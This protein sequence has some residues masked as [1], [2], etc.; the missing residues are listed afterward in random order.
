MADLKILIP[1]NGIT[2]DDD[3]FITLTGDSG[4]TGIDISLVENTP[5]G[6][7]ESLTGFPL[8]NQSLPTS[9]K[10]GSNKSSINIPIEFPSVGE[11]ANSKKTYLLT[12]TGTGGT[13]MGP[14]T[15]THGEL[16]SNSPNNSATM[17]F[18]QYKD[19]TIRVTATITRPDPPGTTD[20]WHF[21]DPGWTSALLENT[22]VEQ[23]GKALTSVESLKWRS[24]ARGNVS[25]DFEMRVGRM[26][27][28]DEVV[29]KAGKEVLVGWDSNDDNKL[30]DFTQ[31]STDHGNV[32]EIHSLAITRVEQ[33]WSVGTIEQVLTGTIDFIKYGT[34]DVTFNIELTDIFECPTCG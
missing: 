13:M 14:Y 6:S 1:Q 31:N 21:T 5:G 26:L 25:V 27:T 11:E 20:T 30:S 16:S 12:T 15:A 9:V 18:V 3:K 32:V 24:D 22:Y 10:V 34:K 8:T 29:V 7:F 33:Y 19:P 23:T 28:G 4:T 2:L 17:N